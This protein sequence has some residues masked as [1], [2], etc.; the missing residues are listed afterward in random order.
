MS[1]PTPAEIAAKMS[2]AAKRALLTGEVEGLHVL[3]ELLPLLTAGEYMND[4]TWN[5]LGLAV[6]AELEKEARH[7]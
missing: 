2:P 5:A 7:D 3:A 6:R 4:Y 1:A